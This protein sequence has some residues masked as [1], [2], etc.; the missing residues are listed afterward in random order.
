[1][2]SKSRLKAQAHAKHRYYC[3]CGV[4]VSGNG[5]KAQHKGMHIRLADGHHYLSFSAY[6]STRRE[7]ERNKP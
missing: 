4:A 5:G 1:V 3:T 6:L 7:A 2:A